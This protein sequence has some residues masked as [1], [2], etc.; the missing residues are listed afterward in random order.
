VL[1]NH[2]AAA[3]VNS[4]RARFETRRG[5]HALAKPVDQF[6]AADVTFWGVVTLCIWSVALLGATAASIVP[7]GV[8][9][10]LH[11]SRLEGASLGQLR[12][13]VATLEADAARLRQD[14]AVL[15]QRFALGEEADSDVTRRVG[16]LEL[17]LPRLLESLN[18]APALDRTTTAG[19]GGG[20]VT[21]LPA[22][23]GSVSFTTI[24]L[25]DVQAAS[26]PPAQPMPEPLGAAMPDS[27]L[28]GVALGAPI[29]A[30]EGETAW[31]DLAT[32]AGA[33]LLG[34]APLVADME[35]GPGKRLVA[36]PIGTEAEA[37][38]ICG[39]FAKIGIACASVPFIGTPLT[40][41]N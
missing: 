8:W 15:L 21:T 22:E 37:R 17:T 14:N 13:Q 9:A 31:Q 36:G 29:D 6:R 12:R 16:A 41:L 32:R 2:Y 40:L 28:F 4:A 33:L 1:E 19:I 27:S 34:L 26:E 38:Q 25:A 35:G 39:R 7:E 20:T 23:G 5:E 30:D 18:R 24:P 11:A 10:G 3:M